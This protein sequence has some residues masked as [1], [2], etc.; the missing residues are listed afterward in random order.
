VPWWGGASVKEGGAVRLAT[1]DDIPPSMRERAGI[2][3]VFDV[4][5]WFAD[6]LIAPI[7]GVSHAIGDL[8][9][10]AESSS[11]VP[12]WGMQFDAEQAE[13]P[14]RWRSPQSSRLRLV[15]TIWNFMRDD[16]PGYRPVLE[17]LTKSLRQ[18]S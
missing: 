1:F 5:A 13:G 4:F 15:R 17:V 10:A 18:S 7:E 9:Y 8:R 2:R 12:L 16:T 14:A 6:G 3:R 11:L